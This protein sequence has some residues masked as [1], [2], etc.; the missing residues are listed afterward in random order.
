MLLANVGWANGGLL[1]LPLWI[2]TLYILLAYKRGLFIIQ[3]VETNM[4]TVKE[5]ISLVL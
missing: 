2:L 4:Y 3:L 1:I 5:K